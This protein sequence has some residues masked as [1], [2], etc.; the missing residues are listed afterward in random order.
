MLLPSGMK[1]EGSNYLWRIDMKI[2]IIGGGAVGMLLAALLSLDEHD[3]TIYVRRKE[4]MEALNNKGIILN[5]F[6][7]KI[8]VKAKQMGDPIEEE[9]VI[10]CVKQYQLSCIIPY[11]KKVSCPLLFLQN[12]MGH[13]KLL[14]ELNKDIPIFVGV[15]EHGSIRENDNSVV[16]TGKGVVRAA[17]YNHTKESS[18]E[19]IKLLST[20][21]FPVLLEKEW[22]IT[23]VNKLVVNAVI[24]PLTAIFDVKNGELLKNKELNK[25]A[26]ILT[27]E[28]CNVMNLDYDLYWR[29]I[30]QICKI[31]ASN[32]SSMRADIQMGRTTEIE[33]LS[34]Y[35]LERDTGNHQGFIQF[36][37]QGVKAMEIKRKNCYSD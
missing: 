29:K 16:H 25:I 28:I 14:K 31:T 1:A 36:T 10:I 6:G 35:L 37:Y 9:L 30:N 27:E 15:V 20:D 7:K 33:S 4:Q 32:T 24:N 17:E 18:T 22:E 26:S 21:R 19:L 8:N 5:P 12:G 23:L 11:I 13:L 34:G 3:L 2:G